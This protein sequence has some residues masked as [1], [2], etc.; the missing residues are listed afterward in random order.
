MRASSGVAGTL[1]RTSIDEVSRRASPMRRIAARTSRTR[2]SSPRAARSVGRVAALS[3]RTQRL[4]DRYAV[5][6]ATLE[7]VIGQAADRGARPEEPD[8][9]R[10]A[11]LVRPGDDLDG[12]AEARA[13]VEDRVDRLDRAKDAERAVE[14]AALGH[15]VEV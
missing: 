15:R 1:A 5:V 7:R 10:C 14:P 3:E 2:W 8:P 11:L 6:V 9:E 4:G 13:R 12:A